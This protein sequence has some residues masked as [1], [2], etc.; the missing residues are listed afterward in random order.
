MG[1][2]IGII[3]NCVSLLRRPICM[4]GICNYEINFADPQSTAT[5]NL[6]II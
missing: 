2:P 4:Y 1:I 3:H 6:Y 5:A